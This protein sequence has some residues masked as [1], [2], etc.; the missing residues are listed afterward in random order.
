MRL[1]HGTKE[2]RYVRTHIPHDE[3]VSSELVP[4]V[5]VAHAGA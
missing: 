4:A 3:E 1:V 5:P 2:D